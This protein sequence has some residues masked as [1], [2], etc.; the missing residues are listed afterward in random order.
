MTASEFHRDAT[1]TRDVS[2]PC[3]SADVTLS[4]LEYVHAGSP[5]AAERRNV[6][7]SWTVVCP[8]CGRWLHA[9][10]EERR[11]AR[12]VSAFAGVRRYSTYRRLVGATWWTDART[13][14]HVEREAS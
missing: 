4:E 10:V 3:C 11:F 2:T 12:N 8:E 14:D 13:G 9:F 6:G 7:T 5:R 1:I